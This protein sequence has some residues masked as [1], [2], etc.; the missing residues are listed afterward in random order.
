M[1]S[2]CIIQSDYQ[3]NKMFLSRDWKIEKDP[4][5]ADLVC[6]TGGEDVSPHYYGETK[7]ASVYT[8]PSRDAKEFLLF[9]ELV[10]KVPMVGI[11]RGGQLLH[12][13]NDGKLWQNVDKHAMGGKHLAYDTVK[14]ESLYVTSAHHQM[15][16]FERGV[17]KGKILLVSVISTRKETDDPTKMLLG[18][19]ACG[20]DIEAILYEDT[21]CLCYQPHPEYPQEKND[22]CTENF[23]FY[24]EN[25]LGVR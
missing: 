11:C 23:F 10:G 20:T 25:L 22:P 5:S 21:G 24:V 18:R 1:K 9:N 13:A 6:F 4:L 17:T 2:V 14:E 16:R 12:V 19:K 8:N 15:M 3:T 7:H